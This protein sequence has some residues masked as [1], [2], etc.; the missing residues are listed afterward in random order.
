MQPHRDRFLADGGAGRTLCG[1]EGGQRL[2]RRA[3]IRVIPGGRKVKN[4]AGLFRGVQGCGE[5]QR[6]GD[7]E[8]FAEVA[9]I[10][11]LRS[12]SR[13][14][15]TPPTSQILEKTAQ[16]ELCSTRT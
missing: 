6:Q 14:L 7:D 12:K 1:G 11:V 13:W 4:E 5:Q 2:G 9:L 16:F 3:G 15:N 10:H 8:G